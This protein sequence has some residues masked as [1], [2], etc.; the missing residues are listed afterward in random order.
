MSHWGQFLD[1]RWNLRPDLAE[2]FRRRC[3]AWTGGDLCG[4]FPIETLE[5]SSSIE[6]FDTDR[7]FGVS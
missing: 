4:L 7:G 5:V 6:I 3:D 2:E 1:H